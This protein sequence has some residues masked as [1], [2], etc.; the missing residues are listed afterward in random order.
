[1]QKKHILANIGLSTIV[2]FDE[3]DSF[4]QQLTQ[5]YCINIKIPI[6]PTVL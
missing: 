3:I 6:M 2:S 1:M 4:P 5:T